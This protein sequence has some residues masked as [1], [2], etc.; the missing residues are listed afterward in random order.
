LL[1]SIL[2]FI[3]CGAV[4]GLNIGC[5]VPVGSP[6]A[7]LLHQ[8]DVRLVVPFFPDDSDKCGPVALASILAYW[9][10]SAPLRDLQDEVYLPALRG[11]LPMDLLAAAKARGLDA[12]SYRGSLSNIIA[13]I[14][15]GHPL[16]ALLD[17]GGWIFSQG[18]FVVITGYDALREGVYVHSGTS[19]DM[20][21][22]YERLLAPWNKTDRWILRAIPANQ[23]GAM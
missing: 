12:T 4:A 10:K 15:E 20:F 11:S 14:N 2:I 16:I 1:K 23:A 9:G 13:E 5:A 3:G 7:S 18:H 19:A 8:S 22:P 6:Q 17:S 21:I